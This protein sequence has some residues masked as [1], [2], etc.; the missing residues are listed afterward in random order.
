MSAAT[1]ALSAVALL[2][3]HTAVAQAPVIEKLTVTDTVALGV[4]VSD[5]SLKRHGETMAVNIDFNLDKT[6]LKGDRVIVFTPILVNGNNS[7]ELNSVS[8]YGRVRWVQFERN[9]R[10]PVSGDGEMSY[11]YS[12]R[13]ATVDFAQTVP[14][15][16]WMRNSTLVLRRNDYGCCN[17]LIN[18]EDAALA[19]WREIVYNPT[20][21]Y[22]RPEAAAQKHRELE[23][24]AYIDFPVDQT[25]IYPNYRRNAIELDTIIAT[26]NV[27]RNDPD[28]TIETVWLKGFA[29]PESPYSHNTD[30]AKGR[31]A[32]LKKYIQNLYHFDGAQI[33]TDYEPEDWEGLRI[34]V[35]NSNLEHRAEILDL[36]DSNMNP[37]AKEAR[38][39]KL[40]PSDYRF[41]LQNF[42]P[43]LR[44]TNYKVNY[45]LRS[46]SDP[47]EILE[48]MRTRPRNLDL[49]EFY[50]AASALEPGS[51]E[52]NEVFETAVRMY[53]N[54]VNA[55]LNAANSAI[56]RH[57]YTSAA[58]YLSRAGDSPEADYARSVLNVLQGNYAEARTFLNQALRA[59]LNVDADELKQLNEL[60]DIYSNMNN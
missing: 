57:D 34:A 31:T 37:D 17:N 11:K 4:S 54:D 47:A 30:L 60:I 10:T 56:S 55:N 21:I 9:H 29:S 33:I 40:Y 14:F 52:F 19:R 53:P 51:D 48:I 35:E 22:M 42:Y 16:D 46:Y 23:G 2:M 1:V 7:L 20:L 27:V 32:A 39:K 59:G 43:A 36:I 28:A 49:D 58:R 13:P 6:K 50:I 26:I 41:M 18:S 3:P 15:A 38:I 25:V 24:K 12:S 44:H 45:T 8:L 5:I